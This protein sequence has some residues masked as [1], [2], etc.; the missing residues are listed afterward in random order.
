MFYV[1]LDVFSGRPN[2]RWSL[3]SEEAEDL[4]ARISRLV[5]YSGRRELPPALGYRGF[6]VYSATTGAPRPWLHV[7]RGVV[8][9]AEP[10]QIRDCSDTEGIEE[11]LRQQASAH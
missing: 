7:G 3:T 1:E 10:N 5:S 9:I 11:L 6:N 2:P 8:K 4:L